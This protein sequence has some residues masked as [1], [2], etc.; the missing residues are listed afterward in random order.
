[1]HFAEQS[2]YII[3]ANLLAAFDINA[4]SDGDGQPVYP[5]VQMSSGLLSYVFLVM[6]F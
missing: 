2:L 6:S 3:T 1:M 5:E 4:P